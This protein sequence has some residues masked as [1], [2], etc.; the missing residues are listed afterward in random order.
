[1]VHVKGCACI[2]CRT[3]EILTPEGKLPGASFDYLRARKLAGDPAKRAAADA[4]R[5]ALRA[6][7]SATQSARDNKGPSQ[8]SPVWGTGNS[9]KSRQARRKH[10]MRQG[11]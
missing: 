4:R 7:R 10:A 1:M 9:K 8:K 5:K 2:Q 3:A 6:A 11:R